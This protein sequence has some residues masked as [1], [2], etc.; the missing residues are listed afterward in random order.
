MKLSFGPVES[1]LNRNDV[2]PSPKMVFMSWGRHAE[3]LIIKPGIRTRHRMLCNF[4]KLT[5]F[6]TDCLLMELYIKL[7]TDILPSGLGVGVQVRSLT[8]TQRTLAHART[9]MIIVPSDAVENA[10]IIPDG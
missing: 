9:K 5:D 2:R 10:A 3:V 7:V 1:F 8:N 4:L 6:I